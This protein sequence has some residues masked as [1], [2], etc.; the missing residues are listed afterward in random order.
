MGKNHQQEHRKGLEQR[1]QGYLWT[2]CDGTTGQTPTARTYTPPTK[3]DPR[4]QTRV[5]KGTWGH[6]KER[7]IRSSCCGSGSTN[8]ASIHEDAGVIPGL[9]RWV[10]DL[11]LP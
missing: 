9:A 10:M 1:E 5:A 8:P 2:Q 4:D 6:L 3:A 7:N 11:A